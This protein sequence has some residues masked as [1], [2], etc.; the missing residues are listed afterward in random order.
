MSG[1]DN[2]DRWHGLIGGREAVQRGLNIPDKVEDLLQSGNE[3]ATEAEA[4]KMLV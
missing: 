1:L 2:L 3:A 4:R